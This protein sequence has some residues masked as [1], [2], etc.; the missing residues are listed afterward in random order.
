MKKVHEALGCINRESFALDRLAKAF[1]ETGNRYVYDLLE[2]IAIELR[3]QVREITDLLQQYEQAELAAA[4]GN[5]A[6][7]LKELLFDKGR[8]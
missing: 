4:R 5:A 8:K 1:Q 3:G 7:T 6:A 2:H